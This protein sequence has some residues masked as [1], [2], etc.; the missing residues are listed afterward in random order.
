[1]IPFTKRASTCCLKKTAGNRVAEHR[2]KKNYARCL[3]A[4]LGNIVKEIPVIH[5]QM[6]IW[7]ERHGKLAETG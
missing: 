7:F 3:L 4:V 2:I 1:M 5:Q 6:H